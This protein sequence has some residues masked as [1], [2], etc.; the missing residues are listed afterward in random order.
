[1]IEN[2]EK[3]LLTEFL[4]YLKQTIK[5]IS[6]YPGINGLAQN[7]DIKLTLF[8]INPPFKSSTAHVPIPSSK[9]VQAHDNS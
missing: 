4:S 5:S 8:T 6:S 2:V 9:L 3:F 1:M 7:V